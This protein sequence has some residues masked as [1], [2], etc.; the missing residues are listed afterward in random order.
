MINPNIYDLNIKTLTETSIVATLG[1]GRSGVYKVRVSRDGW[2][3]NTAAANADKFKYEIKIT[4]VTPKSGSLAGGTMITILG[5]N[6][7]PGSNA[8]FVGNAVNWNCHILTE[9]DTKIEC[10][11]PEKND[12]YGEA[13][14]NVIV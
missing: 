4:E 6:F 9:T 5:V 7:V 10:L 8:V 12:E 13:P 14:V 2:G 11:T 3:Y 1:G